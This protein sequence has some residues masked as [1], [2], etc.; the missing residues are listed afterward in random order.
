MDAELLLNAGECIPPRP[1]IGLRWLASQ[2][3]Q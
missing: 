3:A 2:T 1:L